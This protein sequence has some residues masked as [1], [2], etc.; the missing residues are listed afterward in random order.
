[1]LLTRPFD[2]YAEA[3]RD[4]MV[5]EGMT[6]I[7]ELVRTSR[8]DLGLSQRQL[9]WRVS[10]SQSTISRLESGTLRGMRLQRLAL[11]LGVLRLDPR[12]VHFGEPPAPRR[13]LPGQTS[14]S[15]LRLTDPLRRRPYSYYS[16]W[17]LVAETSSRVGAQ[18]SPEIAR[19]AR[20]AGQS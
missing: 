12:S 14:E 3:T 8:L 1:M 10:M 7:G 9:A 5:R 11:V 2:Q 20:A 4:D 6:V 16:E 19:D 18:V 15:T 13:R 17:H